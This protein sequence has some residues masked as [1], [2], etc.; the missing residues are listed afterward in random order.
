MPN[1]HTEVYIHFV[2]ATQNRQPI[3]TIEYE[4]HLYSFIR[5][6]CQ[7]MQAHFVAIG[8]MPDHIHLLI[9]MPSSLSISNVV[10][11]IKGSSSHF[12]T[13]SLGQT[14]FQWQGAYGAFSVDRDRVYV[15]SNY[16]MNQKEHHAAHTIQEQWEIVED[17]QSSS[18]RTAVGMQSG[19]V[20]CAFSPRSGL[21]PVRTWFQPRDIGWSR[22]AHSHCSSEPCRQPAVFA[23]CDN[24]DTITRY[25]KCK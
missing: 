11:D 2:W 5:S 23:P 15:V 17:V 10:K 8:G 1:S 18:W 21:L 4:E 19:I 13:H 22:L 3:I 12:I 25:C 20:H 14:E 9:R 7:K 16:I 24:Y 6:R